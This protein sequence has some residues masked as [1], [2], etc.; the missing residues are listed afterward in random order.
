MIPSYVKEE[1]QKELAR[2]NF[3][4]Y[5]EYVH[6]GKWL[7]GKHLVF[8]CNKI[9]DLLD[10]RI[11]RLIISLPPQHGKQVA[12]NTPVLTTKGWKNHGDLKIGDYVFGRDG[13]PKKIINEFK[14]TIQDLQVIFTDGQKINVHENHEWLVYDRWKRK[15]VILETKQILD[16]KYFDGTRCRYQVDS[17]VLVDF[18]KKKLKVNPY[19]LGAWLGDGTTTKE[20][21][22]HHKDDVSVI[23][24]VVRFGYPIKAQY[25]HKTT[26][27]YTTYFEGLSKDLQKYN[28]GHRKGIKKY[29]PNSYK[30]SSKEQRLELLA[31]LIDTDGYVYQKTGR[32]TFSNINKQLIDDVNEICIS[33]GFRTTI[34]KYNPITSTSG[35]VG[36]N[37]VY[38]LC[39]NPNIVIP[40]VLPRKKI[41]KIDN[42]KRKR[43]IIKIEK[44]VPEKGKCITVDGGIY[45][46]GKNLIPTHNSQT[47]TE[48]LPS[49]FL[50]KFPNK[51]VIIASYGDDLA[52]RFGRRNKQKIR[53]Y[54]KD[55][56]DIS[57][58]KTSISDTEFEIE[59]H[60]GS[61]I[62]RGIMA[63]I[64]G[65][66]ADLIIIDDPIKNKLEANS[67]IYRDRL[68]EEW[69]NSINT[70]LSADGKIILVQTRWHRQ[71]CAV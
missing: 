55:L 49:Y 42:L 57:L 11:D 25:I 8:V 33:L 45:L 62:S 58:S 1:A 7:R 4:D 52:R 15:E 48:T 12:N 51:R 34:C 16:T 18:T 26:N 46:V 30:V 59:E 54:G 10:N 3:I 41:V 27:T 44:V 38:Q 66:P 29:I 39:F 69:L 32:V 2:R 63:G 19:V 40:T 56:F 5:V 35:I 68:W 43:G 61:V 70:R 20:A 6:N 37:I 36:K 67:Q 9:E 21:I 64:T 47:I 71:I 17:N 14:E 23:N 31:G 65:Q 50:G 13:K 22:T 24:E 53:E 28:L 60:K